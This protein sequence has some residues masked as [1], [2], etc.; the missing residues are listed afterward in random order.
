MNQ[1][2]RVSEQDMNGL[3]ERY[4]GENADEI[5]ATALDSVD[6]HDFDAEVTYFE[7]AIRFSD[8]N[9]AIDIP[10]RPA[11]RTKNS[12][13]LN[14]QV[15]GQATVVELDTGLCSMEAF[16][17]AESGQ[18]LLQH[19]YE[20]AEGYHGYCWGQKWDTGQDVSADS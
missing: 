14:P 1:S 19:V 3:V 8:G 13:D 2:V 10:V 17:I 20:Q 15:A 6:R 11:Y 5:L 7:R 12:D 18:R 16:N 4:L 9:L